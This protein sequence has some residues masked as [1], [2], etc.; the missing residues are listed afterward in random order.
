MADIVSKHGPSF[1]IVFGVAF[2]LSLLLTPLMIRLGHRLNILAKPGGRR[3]HQHPTS[4]LGGL[5]I[6][7]S[8]IVAVIVAQFTDVETTDSNEIV[9]LT[10]LLV[11]GIFIYI[12]GFLDDKYD[13][14]PLVNYL[15]QLTAAAIAVAFL[16]FIES[17]NN[18]FSGNTTSDWPYWITVTISLFWLGLMMNTV[19]F[20]DGL[21]GLAAGV[22]AIASLV[23]F[24]HATFELNQI[25]VGLLPLALFG[26]T[27]GFLPYNFHPAKIF[28]GGGATFVGFTLG[29]LAIIGG[30]KMATILLVMGLPLMDLAWQAI[31]RMSEGRNPMMGDRGHLHLRLVDLGYSQRTIVLG[32]Y[33]FSALF[34]GIALLTTSR[35]YKLL[36]L[37]VMVIMV[38]G[39]FAIVSWRGRSNGVSVVPQSD[40]SK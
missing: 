10:G 25:S 35:L 11:G 5:A 18:P 22:G 9:R 2:G 3:V 31:R 21:D 12:M 7:T 33:V 29:C 23:I 1:L 4:K 37:V 28:M 8:F 17:F 32:Y 38:L 14:S 26:A 30:A 19:N 34:G 27:L 36:G 16:I 15:A 13:F 39:T 20:L 24:L 40:T 6:A